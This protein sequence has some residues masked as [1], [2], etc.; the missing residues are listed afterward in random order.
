MSKYLTLRQHTQAVFTLVIAFLLILAS[1]GMKRKNF[2]NIEH[3][4][5]SVFEDRVVAQEYIHRLNNLF[6]EKK[7]V[8]TLPEKNEIDFI[9]TTEI[10]RLLNDFATTKLTKEESIYLGE[11][12]NDFLLLQSQEDKYSKNGYN[13][14]IEY[15]VEAN[16]LLGKIGTSLDEL[17]KVQVS[18]GRQLTQLSNKSLGMNQLLSNLEIA[19]LVTIGILFLVILFRGENPKTAFKNLD[20]DQLS[21][22]QFN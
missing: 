2:S 7:M 19:S 13:T 6:H 15:Q 21:Y 8:L 11:L 16:A 10:K 20:I 17:S 4:T 22:E 9:K 18:E 5:N 1:G 3:T 12:R 14:K